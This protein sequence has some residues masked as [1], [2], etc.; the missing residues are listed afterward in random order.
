MADKKSTDIV[1]APQSGMI[2]SVVVR[3]K[4]VLRLLADKRVSPLVKLIP[5]GALIY[6]LSPVDILMGVPGLSAVDDAA[7]LGLGY[8]FFL[9]MCPPGVVDEHM[10]AIEGIEEQKERPASQDVVDGEATDIK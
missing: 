4:L 2:H 10:K 5:V 7:V 3:T 9:E 1:T 8:Y 6:L